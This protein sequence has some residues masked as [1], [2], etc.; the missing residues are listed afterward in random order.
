[1]LIIRLLTK[2]TP[3]K[4]DQANTHDPADPPE[5]AHPESNH[6]NTSPDAPENSGS[7]PDYRNEKAGSQRKSPET[8]KNLTC[9]GRL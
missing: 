8:G 4:P 3:D 1:M 5:S 6:N 7:S 9:C 2:I